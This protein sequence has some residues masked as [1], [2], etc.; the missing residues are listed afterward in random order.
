MNCDLFI[1]GPFAACSLAAVYF[2]LQAL[3]HGKRGPPWFGDAWR[4]SSYTPEGQRWLK[5]MKLAIA[6]APFTLVLGVAAYWAFCPEDARRGR[7]E[8]QKAQSVGFPIVSFGP[9]WWLAIAYS[10]VGAFVLARLVRHGKDG[11]NP[12]VLTL[13]RSSSYSDEGRRWLFRLR[14]WL[15]GNVLFWSLAF[16]LGGRG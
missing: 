2:N 11:R 8:Q 12:S 13:L 9:L 10:L 7:H 5:R 1:F 3:N 16:L 15:L 6:C 14:I 4:K